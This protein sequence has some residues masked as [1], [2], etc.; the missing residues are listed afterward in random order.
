MANTSKSYIRL[1]QQGKDELR[2]MLADALRNSDHV[3]AV[4]V[5]ENKRALPTRKRAVAVPEVGEPTMAT[6][7]KKLTKGQKKRA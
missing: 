1:E 4:L 2:T 7:V 5:P 3:E 6:S